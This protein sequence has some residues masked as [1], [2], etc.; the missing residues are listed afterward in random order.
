LK[1]IDFTNIK[2]CEGNSIKAIER[3]L[4]LANDFQIKL[5][6]SSSKSL[7]D[8]FGEKLEKEEYKS[9]KKAL[10]NETVDIL[11]S[12]EPVH[13]FKSDKRKQKK[14]KPNFTEDD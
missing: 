6:T 13:K 3:V 7:T 9:M 1:I 12:E 5:S 2:D 8:L 10:S 14:A 4:K 11:P